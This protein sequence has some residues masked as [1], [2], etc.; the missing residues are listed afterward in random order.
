MKAVLRA[1]L[2][3]AAL[4]IGYV[5]ASNAALLFENYQPLQIGA[6]G[7]L[8]G[9]YGTEFTVGDQPLSVTKL[10]T[11]SVASSA[12]SVGIW[13][14]S[15]QSLVG[16]VDV[17]ST[18]GIAMQGWNFANITPFT[19][20]ANT[21]YRI[22]AETESSTVAWGNRYTLGSGIASVSSGH[23]WAAPPGFHYPTAGRTT[24][25]FLA[26]N[27]EIAPIPEPSSV[28]LLA[29]G[30][31]GLWFARRRASKNGTDRFLS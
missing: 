2:V 8:A 28:A 27:A 18:G 26:A 31:A 16:S 12:M 6:P 13:R 20:L 1:M 5:P 21:V 10:G 3:V 17:P 29:I 4:T 9:T 7:N 24:D 11:F 23:V 14:V 25:V 22:G 30:L 19:L 15:D